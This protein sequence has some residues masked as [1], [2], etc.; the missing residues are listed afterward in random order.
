MAEILRATGASPSLC[1][2]GLMDAGSG[3]KDALQ[4]LEQAFPARLDILEGIAGYLRVNPGLPSGILLDG[5]EQMRFHPLS[6]VWAAGS[7]KEAEAWLEHLAPWFK[8]NLPLLRRRRHWETGDELE[9]IEIH[10][11]DFSTGD[12]LELASPGEVV[13][14]NARFSEDLLPMCCPSLEIRGAEGVKRIKNIH[15]EEGTGSPGH[16]YPYPFPYLHLERLPDLETLDAPAMGEL[17]LRGCP[18]LNRISDDLEATHVVL[19][20]LPELTEFPRG[21]HGA[22]RINLEDCSH[23]RLPRSLRCRDL[24][25]RRMPNV[26]RIP[27]FA[28]REIYGGEKPNIEIHECPNL[29]FPDPY[30]Q[31]GSLT[32]SGHSLQRL[33]RSL[34]IATHIHLSVSPGRA[35]PENLVVGGWL[36]LIQLPDLATIPKSARCATLVVTECPRL[37]FLDGWQPPR[38]LRLKGVDLGILPEG[39]QVKGTL[40]LDSC[41]G[42]HL[43]SGLSASSMQLSGCRELLDIPPETRLETLKVDRCPS[44]NIPKALQERWN[45]Q[46]DDVI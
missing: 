35:L 46:F 23:L 2:Q 6:L 1:L 38:N 30:F 31:E 32:L 10:D 17:E 36:W 21:L 37:R 41:S 28:N 13:L 26:D 33:P 25:L 15:W 24:L 22:L 3:F 44:L 39:L 11:A 16:P 19:H 20:G 34:N 8:G 12:H 5:L 9:S 43:P 42:E 27:Q 40:R 14:H 7:F 45:C 29:R 18:H 4:G